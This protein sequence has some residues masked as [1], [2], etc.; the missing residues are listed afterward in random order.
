[1]VEL[2][3]LFEAG[4]L[5]GLGI[6]REDPRMDDRV[7]RAPA[8]KD[9]GAPP[10]GG[11]TVY[12]S[13]TALELPVLEAGPQGPVD[14]E[15]T[16]RFESAPAPVATRAVLEVTAT[17]GSRFRVELAEGRH[18]I[19]R[20]RECAVWIDDRTLTRRHAVLTVTGDTV[21]IEDEGSLNGTF[22]DGVRLTAPVRLRVGDVVMF[23]DQVTAKL[24]D[25]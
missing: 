5:L 14:P 4:Q 18:D 11:E 3:P 7:V 16:T 23:G 19:G 8:G 13:P 24:V 10:G 12:E 21:T 17:D 25:A 15:A 9:E 22:M 1:M 20:T 2:Q 6:V